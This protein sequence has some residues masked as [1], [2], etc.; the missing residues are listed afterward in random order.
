MRPFVANW[1]DVARSLFERVYRESI[2]RVVD[3]KTRELLAALLAYPD[4]N[5]DWKNPVAIGF[6]P[7]IPL[8]FI[9]DGRRLN[10]FSMVTTVGPPNRRRPGTAHRVHVPSRRGDRN[11]SC[12]DDGYS[13]AP[14][15][16]IAKPIGRPMEQALSLRSPTKFTRQAPPR[17]AGVS[18][19]PCARPAPPWCRKAQSPS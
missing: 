18:P 1:P 14:G 15:N 7:V 3:E 8:G 10:Y 5:S 6:M 19:F 11:P 17:P 9:K 2:G 13:L 12:R 4:V 16:V